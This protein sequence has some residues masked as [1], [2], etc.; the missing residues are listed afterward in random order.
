[1]ARK[2]LA[3]KHGI[4]DQIK[5]LITNQDKVKYAV[6]MEL[7]QLGYV[8]EAERVKTVAVVEAGRGRKKII[9]APTNKGKTLIAFSKNWKTSS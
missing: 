5:T 1:M 2:E 4:V 6:K 7:V 3:N 9:Y 8:A